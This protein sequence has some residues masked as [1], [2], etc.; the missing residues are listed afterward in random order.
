MRR[1]GAGRG[2]GG[3]TRLQVAEGVLNVLAP[4]HQF[5]ADTVTLSGGNVATIPNRRGADA[6]VLTSGTIAAPA[7]D[8][9]FGGAQSIVLAGPYLDSNL[10]ASAFAFTAD[11]SGCEVFTVFCPA[12]SVTNGVF[13]ATGNSGAGYGM[14]QKCNNASGT[15][16]YIVRNATTTVVS[17]AVGGQAAAGVATYFDDYCGST[18]PLQFGALTKQTASAAGAFS[19]T[20]GT[21]AT[22]GTLRLG[23]QVNGVNTGAV[24]WCE[25]L[26]FD[27][28][29]SEYDRQLVR[30]YIAAR[31]GIAAPLVTGDDRDILSMVPFAGP[32]A[33]Y[34]S[35]LTGKVTSWLDRSRPGHTFAQA[36]GGNQVVTPTPDAALLNALSA[37]F[38]GGQ[39]YASNLPA[40]AWKFI[41]DGTGFEAYDVFVP[42]NPSATSLI[43]GTYNPGPA[44]QMQCGAANVVAFAAY[45]AAGIGSVNDSGAAVLGART[46]S[47]LAMASAASPQL[48]L[49]VNGRTEQTS[50][51]GTPSASAPPATMR[52]GTRGDLALPLQARWAETLWFARVLSTDE[53]ARMANYLMNR[54]GG[55]P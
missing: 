30:E 17:T 14:V 32:R 55:V 53:R 3:A 25:T 11:G 19:A 49:R 22:T 41:H 18:S 29:L 38:L 48:R 34:Y 42:T 54:Y 6:L 7:S 51:I 10:P 28:V 39:H 44:G 15:H 4:R 35:L 50:A 8:I 9:I 37:P 13:L 16:E 24:R 45:A 26:I 2:G 36:T 31:Y 43:W 5:R 46:I 1:G 23:S 33:D 27:R 21:G 20:P 47:R 40:L 52:L 12:D